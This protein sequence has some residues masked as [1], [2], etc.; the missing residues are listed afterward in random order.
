MEE[1]NNKQRTD[2]YCDDSKNALESAFSRSAFEA[3]NAPTKAS[4]RFRNGREVVLQR[5][6][7]E[8]MSEINRG[9]KSFT[10]GDVFIGNP[11]VSVDDHPETSMLRNWLAGENKDAGELEVIWWLAIAVRSEWSALPHRT[12][13]EHEKLYARIERLCKELIDSLADTESFYKRAGGWGLWRARVSSLLTDSEEK[14]LA[15]RMRDDLSPTD[16]ELDL[17]FP[18]IEELL[19]RLSSAADRLKRQGPVHA[20]PN[21]RGAERGYFVRRM[22]ELFVQRYGKISAEAIASLTTVALDE[23]TDRELVS[24]LLKGGGP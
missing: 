20:Q 16:P 5:S 10:L 23:P 9:R 14:A 8:A 22:G 19:E 24:K 18:T 21:K 1:K 7:L 3:C 13:S 12:K 4:S 6:F 17:A 15:D 2:L 11:K